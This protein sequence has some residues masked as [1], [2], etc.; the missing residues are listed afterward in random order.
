MTPA[1]FD[2]LT[3]VASRGG[4][5]QTAAGGVFYYSPSGDSFEWYLRAEQLDPGVRYRLELNVDDSLN[6]AA[7]SVMADETGRALGHGELQEFA[8]R[9]CVGAVSTPPMAL[10]GEHAVAVRLKRDGSSPGESS[11]ESSVTGPAS[12]PL[13]CT[14]NGDGRFDYVLHEKNGAHFT[15]SANS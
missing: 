2:S 11:A 14:G 4:D 13:P 8:D 9:Y 3:L 1:G 12:R 15:G 5:A 6:Y 7:G 10:A